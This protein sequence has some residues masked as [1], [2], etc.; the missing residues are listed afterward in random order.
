MWQLS[1]IHILGRLIKQYLRHTIFFS[2]L[3]RSV[4]G[5][6][7]SAAFHHVFAVFSLFT[8]NRNTICDRTGFDKPCK[9]AVLPPPWESHFLSPNKCHQK[10]D[11]GY[12]YPPWS[13]SK[14]HINVTLTCTIHWSSTWGW[15]PT[16][17]APQCFGTEVSHPPARLLWLPGLTG[18]S[19]WYI[20]SR[21]LCGG[22]PLVFRLQH[23]VWHPCLNHGHVHSMWHVNWNSRTRLSAFSVCSG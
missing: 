22:M 3:C 13:K 21:S 9:S 20:W 5:F 7:I 15:F 6:F 14:T 16:W 8:Q 10:K 2:F 1:S 23:A 4:Y 12:D 18:H 19:N 17:A 11:R